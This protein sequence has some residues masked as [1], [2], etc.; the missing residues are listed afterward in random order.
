MNR[1]EIIHLRMNGSHSRKAAKDLLATALKIDQDEI[2]QSVKIYRH[3]S[4]EGDLCVILDWKSADMVRSY[5]DLGLQLTS[6]LKEFGRVDHT[7]WV[8]M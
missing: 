6:S 5:S 1:V 7:I 3:Q 2:S 4:I 8:E